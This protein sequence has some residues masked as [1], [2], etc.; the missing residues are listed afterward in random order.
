M[1]LTGCV[2]ARRQRREI[3]VAVPAPDSRAALVAFLDLDGAQVRRVSGQAD[4]ESMRWPGAV[5][6]HFWRIE[7]P[8]EVTGL[9]A[10]VFGQRDF[11]SSAVNAL[12]VHPLRLP[13]SS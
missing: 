10:A 2:Y 5:P 13:K 11:D 7:V 12:S 4:V 9:R 8:C 3:F 6:A 1:P